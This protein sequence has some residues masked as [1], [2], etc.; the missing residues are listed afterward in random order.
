MKTQVIA[1]LANYAYGLGKKVLLV[2]PGK[3]ALDEL[4]KR[5]KNVFGLDIPSKDGRIKAMITSGLLNRLDYKDPDKRL[6]LEKEIASFDWIM[7]DEVEY[8]IN[9]SGEYLFSCCTGAECFYA[10]SGTASKKD[11]AMISFV[12]GLDDVV[13]ENRNLVKFFGPNLVYRVPLNKEI[14]DIQIKTS[15]LDRIPFT[16]EDFDSSGNVYM[17]IMTRI[18][19]DP[20][21]CQLIVKLIAKYPLLFIPINNLAN[22]LTEWID[23]W[24][25]HRFKILLVCHEGYIYYD[26]N[27]NKEKL[28]LSQACD[29][30]RDGKVDVIPS[31]SSGYRALDLP[32]LEN[33]LLV[34]GLKAGVVLQSIGRIARSAH[35]NIITLSSLAGK[36]IPVYSKSDDSRKELYQTYYKYCNIV[37]SVI[38]ET[39]L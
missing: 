36:K 6:L 34:E 24:F 1:T 10:F 21:I 7:V 38:Y 32:N 30:I 17:N 22:I 20:G 33:I 28:N 12:N 19:T 2:A 14:D 25:L 16:K 27:G 39:N 35:M 26:L 11:G 37:E 9:D 13:I 15:A 5:C 4:V 29:Y 3:K 18:W 31:T 8:T 23:N